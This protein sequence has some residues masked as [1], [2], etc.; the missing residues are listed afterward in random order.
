[1]VIFALLI[2]PSPLQK[3][4]NVLVNHFPGVKKGLFDLI[5]RVELLM[6]NV[7][8]AMGFIRP[9]V[10]NTIQLGFMHIEEAKPLNDGELKSFLDK[11][12]H[13]VIYMSFGSNINS[14]DLGDEAVEKFLNVFKRTKF[15][16]LWKFENDHLPNKPKN[17]MTQKWLPQADLL[18]HPKIKLFI[19]QGG[20][21][22]VEEAI[23]R[24]VPMIVI[25]FLGDQPG[26]AIKLEQKGVGRY[27]DF[28]NITE[29][30]LLETIEEMTK[31]IYKD[32]I[33]KLRELVKDD[34]MTSREKAVWWTEYV[35]RHKGAKHLAYPGRLVPFYQ[36]YCLDFITIGIALFYIIIKLSKF[37]LRF[38]SRA[39]KIKRE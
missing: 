5:D 18:A 23:D 28:D 22:S 13:G 35:I 1:M 9:L 16:V 30:H 4:N 29:N 17:V 7:H 37:I 15:D 12:E 32:N 2:P 11:S 24:E 21:Q 36:K 10:P 38:L 33:K 14:K 34:P 25:P 27:I 19:T 6:V 26:M 39:F 20:Q 8:P 31:P 3:L